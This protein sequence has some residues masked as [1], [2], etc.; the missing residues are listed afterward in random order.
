[1]IAD[2]PHTV[3]STARTHDRRRRE[4]SQKRGRSLPGRHRQPRWGCAAPF[5]NR[6]TRFENR[7]GPSR[8]A[9]AA[10][11]GCKQRSDLPL[12]LHIV[13]ARYVAPRRRADRLTEQLLCWRPAAP[14]LRRKT[15]PALH[16]RAFVS[17]APRPSLMRVA[18]RPVREQKHAPSLHPAL[19]AVTHRRIAQPAPI[20]ITNAAS[21]SRHLRSALRE[22]VASMGPRSG[23]P[24]KPRSSRSTPSPWPRSAKSHQLHSCS[25][26]A[27]AE[28]QTRQTAQVSGLLQNGRPH[29]CRTCSR[30]SRPLPPSATAACPRRRAQSRWTARASRSSPKTASS[31]TKSS[32]QPTSTSPSPRLPSSP[33]SCVA[34]TPPVQ[35]AQSACQLR[36]PSWHARVR[37]TSTHTSAWPAR[38]GQGQGT[39]QDRAGGVQGGD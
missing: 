24:P 4:P 13:A 14:A 7:R 1:M 25:Q 2:L 33:S 31:S 20:Q 27:K 22:P 32:L 9:A 23:F 16:R 28:L 21:A 38:A 26:P 10:A 19:Q 29:L 15:L 36:H 6:C 17:R 18:A 12:L 5:S 30:S 34:C 37:R 39:A 8:R 3:S 11:N 35:R